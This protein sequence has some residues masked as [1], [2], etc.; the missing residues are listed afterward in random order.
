MKT[1]S[2]QGSSLKIKQETF[3][4]SKLTENQHEK[5]SSDVKLKIKITI[6]RRFSVG[7]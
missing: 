4:V 6:D 2:A 1:T 5:S 7:E 3:T